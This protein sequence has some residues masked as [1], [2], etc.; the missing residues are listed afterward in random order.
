MRVRGSRK[1]RFV[2]ICHPLKPALIS[3][4]KLR[5]PVFSIKGS[6]FQQSS[7]LVP[8]PRTSYLLSNVPRP[9]FRVP[10]PAYGLAKCR[11]TAGN[12]FFTPFNGCGGR[13]ISSM[14]FSRFSSSSLYSPSC[15]PVKSGFRWF[16]G[17]RRSGPILSCGRWG[18]F[19]RSSDAANWTRIAPI[20]FVRTTALTSTSC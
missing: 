4:D 7:F 3:I 16:S 11:K 6:F 20:S 18:S 12:T 5:M 9:S 19:T 14:P 13:S 17:S 2:T 10:C 1:V 8:R 15:F